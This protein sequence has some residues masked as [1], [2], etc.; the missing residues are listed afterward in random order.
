MTDHSSIGEFGVL[1][2]RGFETFA[3][4]DCYG[5]EF[6]VHQSAAI[7]DTERGMDNPGSS[8]VWIGSN[9]L[10]R[11]HVRAVVTVLQRWLDTGKLSEP[12]E[13]AEER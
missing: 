6:S 8:F 3:L 10:G 12:A 11:D 4:T 1:S 9:H 7:D 5:E 2:N 13:Q